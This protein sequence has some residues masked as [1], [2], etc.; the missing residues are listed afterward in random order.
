MSESTNTTT[1]EATAE[2]KKPMIEKRP[3]TVLEGGMTY[4]LISR[5]KNSFKRA[6]YEKIG[7][8]SKCVELVD[9]RGSDQVIEEVFLTIANQLGARFL[10]GV[11]SSYLRPRLKWDGEKATLVEPV[12]PEAKPKEEKKATKE[13]KK[14]RK[15]A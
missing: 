11:K 12:K 8:G 10:A 14:A 3:K 1:T 6:D 7:K 9:G 13:E 15:T 4:S 2:V 5:V